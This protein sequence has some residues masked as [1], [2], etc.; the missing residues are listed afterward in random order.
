VP[1]DRTAWIIIALVV[2]IGA[3]IS[4]A[5]GLLVVVA[6]DSSNEERGDA[7]AESAIATRELVAF[8]RAIEAECRRTGALP[9]TAGPVPPSTHGLRYAI[10]PLSTGGVRAVVQGDVDHDGTPVTAAARCNDCRCTEER[11]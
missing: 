5:L 4:C 1:K 2:G 10:E 6:G 7:A 8:T 11:E 3:I 9:Q